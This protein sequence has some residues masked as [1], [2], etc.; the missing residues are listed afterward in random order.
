MRNIKVIGLIIIIVI[1]IIGMFLLPSIISPPARVTV[2]SSN[3]TFAPGETFELAI[4]IDPMGAYIAGAKMNIAFDRDMVKVNKITEGSLFKQ[5]NAN[6][7]FNGGVVDNSGGTVTNIYDVIIGNSNVSNPGIFI[8]INL[9]VL[10]SSGPSRINIS[11]VEISDP[12]GYL[13]AINVTNGTINARIAAIDLPEIRF[14][15]GTV[16]DSINKTGIAGVTVSTNTSFHATTDASGFY[17]LGLIAG[18]YEI[19]AKF[20]PMY[21]SNNTIMASTIENVAVVQDIEL[22]KKPTGRMT[23]KVT[24]S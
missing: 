13:I 12:D 1:L 15:N 3:H 24:N 16:M 2:I 18:S 9:T 5:K 19:T 14:I 22:V 21:Y 17:S 11:N 8:N 7:F 23:G 10:D 6:T 4:L 20:D